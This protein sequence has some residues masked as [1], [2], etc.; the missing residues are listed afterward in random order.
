VTK[1]N[2]DKNGLITR[3][4][5]ELLGRVTKGGEIQ[6]EDESLRSDVLRD[7]RNQVLH[8]DFIIWSDE[9]LAAAVLPLVIHSGKIRLACIY[10]DTDDADWIDELPDSWEILEEIQTVADSLQIPEENSPNHSSFD[11]FTHLGICLCCRENQ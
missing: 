5:G 2:F 6:L 7:L 4:D 10:C 11:W 1:Y 3:L 8:D 9:L